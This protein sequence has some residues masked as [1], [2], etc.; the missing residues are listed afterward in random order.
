MPKFDL[1]TSIHNRFDIEVRDAKTGELKQK[2]EAYNVICDTLWD[3]LCAHDSN[4]NWNR[5]GSAYNTMICFGTGTGTPSSSDT[6]LFNYLGNK[7]GTVNRNITHFLDQHVYIVERTIVLNPEE[8]VGSDLTEVGISWTSNQIATHALIKDLNG[9]VISIHKT[10]TDIITII[11][12]IYLHFNDFGNGSILIDYDSYIDVETGIPRSIAY[13][14]FFDVLCGL[15]PLGRP[16][17]SYAVEAN[18][19]VVNQICSKITGITNFSTDMTLINHP[20]NRSSATADPVNKTITLNFERLQASKGNNVIHRTYRVGFAADYPDSKVDISLFILLS[21]G[22]YSPAAIT[23]EAIGT[24]D[25]T[26]AGFNTHFPIKTI[27]KVYID[28]V[29]TNNYS[30]VN[31]H[32]PCLMLYYMP[33]VVNLRNDIYYKTSVYRDADTSGYELYEYLSQPSESYAEENVF[34]SEFGIKRLDFYCGSAWYDPPWGKLKLMASDDLVTWLESEE[35]YYDDRSSSV[36]SYTLPANMKNK[37]FYK[38][39][40]TSYGDGNNDRLRVWYRY[41]ADI[42]D[43]DHN[44]VFSTPPAAG[45][46][47]TIDYT[48]DCIA[49]DE[50]HV[51][52][53]SMTFTLNESQVI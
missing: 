28:G 42:S 6:T 32:K 39:K 46:V 10:D 49:K 9:N 26:T 44:I 51:F 14:V 50:N 41:I 35:M 38:L 24:G 25:G 21:K 4:N 13:L 31:V 36:Q 40:A 15:Y 37:R 33:A 18:A 48:P 5:N 29:E 11:G 47:I 17:S 53:L 20:I 1:K 34:Y 45:S 16:G 52:D 19:W 43:D 27:S 8:Y 23:Q 12:S 7:A 22:W 30:Y 2:A 3:R